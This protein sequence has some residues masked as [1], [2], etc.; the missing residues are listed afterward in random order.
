MTRHLI[1]V[2]ICLFFKFNIIFSQNFDL[3][4]YDENIHLIE[5]HKKT[6]FNSTILLVK[7]KILTLRKKGYIQATYDSIIY[8]NDKIYV[9]LFIGKKYLFDSI[10]FQN[11]NKTEMKKINFQQ[12][13]YYGKVHN[14]EK[15]KILTEN[16][17]IYHENNGYPF[18][19]VAYDSVVTRNSKI[20]YFFKIEKNN[21]YK[22]DSIFILSSRKYSNRFITNYIGITAGS[23][24]NQK[25][26]N[27]ISKTLNEID[28]IEVV[29]LPEL[30]FHMT[31][32]DLYIYLNRK[33]SNIFDVLI[34]FA[35]ESQT[36]KL[37]VSGDINLKILNSFNLGETINFKWQKYNKLSQNL[38]LNLKLPYFLS[39]NFGFNNS[40]LIDKNDT[41]Y[42]TLNNNF[43]IQ[44]YFDGANYIEFYFKNN[45]S[46]PL[47]KDTTNFVLL[48][49][50]LWGI[51]IFAQKFDNKYNPRRGYLLNIKT[52]YG[53]KQIAKLLNSKQIEGEILLQKFVPLPAKFTLLF[54]NQ[55][56]IIANNK[57]IY[58]NELYKIGGH[59]TIRGLSEK[60]INTSAYSI[61][62]NEIRYLFDKNSNFYLFNEIT[63]YK[64]YLP[65][66]KNLTTPIFIQ[67]LGLGMT[68]ATANGI[69]TISY[70]LPRNQKDF[71]ILKTAKIHFGYISVF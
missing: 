27:E 26:I 66:N 25:K 3:Y 56:K 51:I 32:A 59:N 55:T 46:F 65:E 31:G 70:A 18:V 48:N 2:I 1:L 62:T 36:Q 38:E 4:I 17:L 44:Y 68:F 61:F 37:T 34:G 9:Y 41:N 67:G 30:E 64:K 7:N 21:F 71:F 53:N 47:Q 15:I 43:G 52:G 8:A 6:E 54:Q 35:P 16:I 29:R 69:F 58:L 39:T 63:Y 23:V 45:N 49:T 42:L 33:R 57:A 5:T 12:Q 24:Y 19:S 60:I 13:D 28:F 10:Y 11:I 20:S 14:S 40:F 50:K 22:I